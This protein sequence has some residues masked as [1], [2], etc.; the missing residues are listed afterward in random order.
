MRSRSIVLKTTPVTKPPPRIV[1]LRH[2]YGTASG[3]WGPDW[4]AVEGSSATLAVRA[5]GAR[6][7]LSARAVTRSQG[8]PK[9]APIAP[10]Q[11]LATNS[12]VGHPSSPE[13]HCLNAALA[14][15]P[16]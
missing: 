11:R 4:R 16:S 13:L 6:Q 5:G 12:A 9:H 7:P 14:L 15:W 8:A 2:L 1:T 3:P 10:R